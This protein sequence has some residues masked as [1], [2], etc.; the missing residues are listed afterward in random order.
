MSE[1]R[2]EIFNRLDFDELIQVILDSARQLIGAKIGQ[3]ILLDKEDLV[4][5]ASTE[6]ADLGVRLDIENS[7]SGQAIKQKEILNIADLRQ[8]N[9]ADLH[10]WFSGGEMRSELIAPLLRG[11]SVIGVLNFES[12]QINAFSRF[13]ARA[14]E[15][16]AAEVAIA[17][18]LS[19]QRTIQQQL[20]KL[21]QRILSNPTTF[22]LDKGVSSNYSNWHRLARC[23][24]RSNSSSKR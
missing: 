16:L 20:V 24:N 5:V 9:Y 11:D 17:I 19:R 1:I 18:E 22:N 8:K 3:L 15:S 6:E 7:I 14:L 2:Q 12:P 13:N 4:I 10:K 23:P 21:Q